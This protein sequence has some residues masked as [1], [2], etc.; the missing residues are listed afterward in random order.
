MLFVIAFFAELLI[1]FLMSKSLINHIFSFFYK[2]TRNKKISIYIM[3]VIF[4]T[5]T[6]IHEMSHYFMSIILFVPAGNM[7]LVPKIVG[8]GVKLG[9]VQIGRTDPIRRLFIGLA[10]FLF[11]NLIILGLFLYATQN[12][13][14]SNPTYII[15]VSYFVFEIGNTMFSSKKDMEGAIE[16]MVTLTVLAILLYFVGLRLPAANPS[17]IFSNPYLSQT[18]QKADLYILA[19]IGIDVLLTGLLRFILR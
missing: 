18:F 12:H 13:L 16:V 17:T 8:N 1:L 14:F 4:F 2:F 3:S 19:P 6:V 5:G 9:S 10:P 7:T 11:G 15:F